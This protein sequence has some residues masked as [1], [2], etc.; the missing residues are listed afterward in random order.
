VRKFEVGFSKAARDFSASTTA[1]KTAGFSSIS[2][3]QDG[4]LELPSPAT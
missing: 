2:D 3:L 1:I 4:G